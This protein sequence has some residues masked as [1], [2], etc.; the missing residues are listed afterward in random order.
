MFCIDHYGELGDISF[1]DIHISP[2]SDDKVGIN[3]LIVRKQDWLDLLIECKSA[4]AIQLDEVSFQIVSNSQ[5]MSFKKKGRNGA[6][7]NIMKKFGKVT[8]MYDVD[9][10]RQPTNRDY[11]EYFQ[12]RFQQ[13]LGRHK[14]LWPFIKILKSKVN[15]H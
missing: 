6:F 13:F 9:Y 4:G 5:R 8:P 1:G 2:Y 7:V 14:I 3:S 12:N 15:M 11:I 10:L